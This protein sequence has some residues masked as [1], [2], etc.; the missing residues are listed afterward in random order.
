MPRNRE[1]YKE[2]YCESEIDWTDHPPLRV[3]E[4]CGEEWNTEEVEFLNGL[5]EHCMR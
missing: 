5:C 4:M 1:Y 3:C 2:T